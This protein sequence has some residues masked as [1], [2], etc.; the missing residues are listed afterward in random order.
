[1]PR[2][3]C[4]PPPGWIPTPCCPETL[5]GPHPSGDESAERG[6]KLYAELKTVAPDDPRAYRALGLFYLSSGQKEKA[7][8]EFQSLLQSK[9]K[10]AAVK[11]NL[12]GV[13]IDL[14]RTKEAQALNQEVLRR[15]PGDRK[16]S[17]RMAGLLMADGKY[18]EATA[19]LQAAIKSEPNCARCYF[20]SVLRRMALGLTDFAKASL[21][22]ARQLA[23][24]M[25]GA[26]AALAHL[27][28]NAGDLRRRFA[29]G[30]QCLAGQ[31]GSRVSLRDGSARLDFERRPAQSRRRSGGGPQTR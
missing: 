19:A 13:L 20:F 15:N 14:K 2:R 22:R 6:G 26:T 24:Q 4:E 29:I 31:S 9:P 27:D 10:D 7:A 18:Q 25:S 8:A 30:R 28:A 17:S 21:A 16:L 1:M 23:P 3:K 11:A 12:I 5:P